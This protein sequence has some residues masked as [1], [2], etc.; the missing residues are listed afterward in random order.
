MRVVEV[1]LDPY[2]ISSPV[3]RFLWCATRNHPICQKEK[4]LEF[5][6]R[7]FSSH[8]PAI[9]QCLQVLSAEP[10]E[11]FIWRRGRPRLRSRSPRSL[12]RSPLLQTPN[13]APL[14]F[15]RLRCGALSVLIVI[16]HQE[17]YSG[18]IVPSDQCRISSSVIRPQAYI[19]GSGIGLVH[20]P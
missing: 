19:L 15:R 13:R 20:R 3:F 16:C 10:D 1:H 8:A 11:I 5:R 6:V 2:M 12:A 17:G 14:K 4:F 7:H 18:C 9:I